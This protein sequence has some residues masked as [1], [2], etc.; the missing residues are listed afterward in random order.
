VLRGVPTYVDSAN[1]ALGDVDP[2]F[3]LGSGEGLI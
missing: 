3:S 2:R 1:P